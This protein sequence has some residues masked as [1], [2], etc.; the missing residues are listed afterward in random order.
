MSLHYILDAY[1]ILHQIPP[2]ARKEFEDEREHFVNL[3]KV[4]CPQ[5]SKNNAV[6]IVFDGR[7]TAPLQEQSSMIKII[8]SCEESADDKIR[9]LITETNRKKQTIVV[10]DD[11]EL[12]FSIRALGASVLSVK[13]FLSKA[14]RPD[15]IFPRQNKQKDRRD[16]VKNI[17]KT[18]E[19]KINKEFEKIWLDK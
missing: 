2:H 17:S 16:E 5:G 19:F 3:I 9:K 4:H 14:K 6:T 11:K 13:D 1:N 10:T 12:R 8:F 18:L 15:R 7:S